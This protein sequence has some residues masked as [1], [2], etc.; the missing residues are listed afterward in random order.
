M[1]TREKLDPF[2]V[3]DVFLVNKTTKTKRNDKSPASALAGEQV[4]KGTDTDPAGETGATGTSLLRRSKVAKGAL[5]RSFSLLFPSRT[6]DFTVA[7]K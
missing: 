3:D 1:D 2:Q 5:E 4:R 7:T 6:L